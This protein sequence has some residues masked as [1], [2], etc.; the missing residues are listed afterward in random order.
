MINQFAKAL[1][2]GSGILVV[3]VSAGLILLQGG[4]D[5]RQATVRDIQQ[6]NHHQEHLMQTII[7]NQNVIIENQ[8]KLFLLLGRSNRPPE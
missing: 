6:V 4:C 2:T 3:A 7:S 5:L 8:R 1:L